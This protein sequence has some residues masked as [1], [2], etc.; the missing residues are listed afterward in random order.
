MSHAGIDLHNSNNF[1]VVANQEGRRLFEQRLPNDLQVIL[2]QLSEYQPI[3]NVVLK[4]A[5]NYYWLADGLL[6]AGYKTLLANPLAMQ[7]YSGLKHEDDRYD[8]GWM[9]ELQRLGILPT[10]HLYSRQRRGLRDVLRQR[11]RWVRQKTQSLLS[12]QSRYARC[13]GLQLSKSDLL[14]GR[15]PDLRDEDQNLAAWSQVQIIQALQAQIRILEERVSGQLSMDGP[16]YGRLTAIDGIGPVL[17]STIT[18]ETGDLGRFGRAGK[19]ASYARVVNSGKWS[20]HS[21]LPVSIF[22]P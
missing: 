1:T 22:A 9:A 19:Y 3:E 5:Y 2:S 16:L 21:I 14:G 20:N 6:D 10:S 11:S 13:L 18:L 4:R 15:L 17:A 8:A 12:L 7:P